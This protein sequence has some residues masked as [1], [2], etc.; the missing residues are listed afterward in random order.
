MSSCTQCGSEVKEG[1]MFCPGCGARTDVEPGSQPKPAKKRDQKP[2][3]LKLKIV[4]GIMGIMCLFDAVDF[5]AEPGW[6]SLVSILF[7]VGVTVGIFKGFEGVRNILVALSWLAAGYGVLHVLVALA[8]DEVS[9]LNVLSA[10]FSLAWPVSLII[11]LR[12]G[13]V[14]SW[15]FSRSAGQREFAESL[16]R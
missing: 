4:L 10:L 9:A 15:I 5:L 1:V 16:N 14:R 2:V 6:M 12:A 11:V 13:D 7:K 3:P 8:G